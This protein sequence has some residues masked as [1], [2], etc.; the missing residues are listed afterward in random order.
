[1]VKQQLIFGRNIVDL[2]LR[3][4]V[5]FVESLLALFYECW[6]R[7]RLLLHKS[8]EL[9]VSSRIIRDANPGLCVCVTSCMLL[10]T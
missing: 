9:R 7:L 6:Q 3:S 2:T 8:T 1:L 5:Q 4:S 10:Q